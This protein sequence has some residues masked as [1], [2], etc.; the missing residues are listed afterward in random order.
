[1][2]APSYDV[3]IPGFPGRTPRGFLGWSTTVLLH[4]KDGYALFDTGGACD[5]PGILNALTHR[6]LTPADIRTVVLSH[7]HFDHIAN[8]ECFP[9]A[10]LV[11]HETELAYFDEY[12]AD[13]RA[14]PL[15]QVEGL[16]RSPQLSLVSGELDVLPGIRMIRTPGHTGG[17]ASLVLCVDGKC[18]VLAQDAVKHRGEIE[19]LNS[20]GAF[21]NISARESIR[22]IAA[23]ADIVVP[24]HDASLTIANGKVASAGALS[25][26][27][28]LTLKDRSF[29]MEV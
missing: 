11:L 7:L 21:D 6:G 29:V 2:T 22:R 20:A 27:I 18:I 5:R 28:S 12:K 4:T 13:D 17:H 25:E 8:V 14:I 9:K 23:M 3:L 15:F 19:T 24:G 16:L 10:E 26:V 1:M